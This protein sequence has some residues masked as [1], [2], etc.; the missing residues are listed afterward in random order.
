MLPDRAV[1]SRSGDDVAIICNESQEIFYV[2]CQGDR[3]VGEMGNCTKTGK[4]MNAKL[5]SIYA[6]IQV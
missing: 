5:S 3:W 2:T 6:L 1:M 4:F